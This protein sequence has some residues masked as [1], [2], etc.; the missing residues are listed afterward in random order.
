[1]VKLLELLV[2]DLVS[3]AVAESAKDPPNTAPQFYFLASSFLFICVCVMLY[4][5]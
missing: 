3:G 5:L 4:V 1:M 2:E